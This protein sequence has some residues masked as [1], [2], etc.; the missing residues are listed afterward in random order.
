MV[1]ITHRGDFTKK[2]SK[3]LKRNRL[4]KIK[5]ILDKYG[6]EGV[7]LLSRNT[8]R[9]TGKTADSWGY[10]LVTTST[11]VAIQWYNTNVVEGWANVALLLQYGHFNK[12]GTYLEGIDYINPALKPIFKKMGSEIREEVG[13]I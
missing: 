11:G 6:K 2:M 5:G 13:R 12:D 9:D 3:Y 4:D 8:P 7:E 1:T 10:K